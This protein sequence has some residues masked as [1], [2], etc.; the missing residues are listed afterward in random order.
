[1]KIYLHTKH[2]LTADECPTRT[3]RGLNALTYDAVDRYEVK[4][5]L[6]RG[7][8]AY[9]QLVNEVATGQQYAAKVVSAAMAGIQELMT[10]SDQTFEGYPEFH[11]ECA[12]LS[13]IMSP[14][15]VALKE[16]TVDRIEKEVW[17]VLEY[18]AA[19]CIS[20]ILGRNGQFPRARCTR[21][22][23]RHLSWSRRS[24]FCR[25]PYTATLNPSNVLLAS[26]GL[27]KIGDFGTSVSIFEA[28]ELPTSARGTE[29]Y[30]A[31]ELLHG[32]PFSPESDVFA[33]GLT[34]L[35]LLG[36][37]PQGAPFAPLL[38]AVEKL[39]PS[40][41]AA[42]LLDFFA[43]I[44]AVDPRSRISAAT[45][46]A[47]PALATAASPEEMRAFASEIAKKERLDREE[48]DALVARRRARVVAHEARRCNAD[49]SS[50]SDSDTDDDSYYHDD[51][52]ETGNAG[53]S[54]FQS[55]GC[56][57][58][59]ASVVPKVQK[60]CRLLSSTSEPES[61][62]TLPDQHAWQRSSADNISQL[63]AT[64]SIVFPRHPRRPGACYMG[65][66]SA[67]SAGM[68]VHGDRH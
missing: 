4:A 44:V 53:S 65:T 33:A 17:F 12:V 28:A 24:P 68:A 62:G 59:S 11:R 7:A 61:S 8:T 42:R 21:D 52:L 5:R 26:S 63:P 64:D 58:G 57:G 38:S 13:R 56:M 54:S 41:H 66:S 49:Y 37:K 2:A 29:G 39:S 27:A 15:L 30:F 10:S 16:M 47:H 40:Q 43:L 48:R 25:F 18:C 31:P 9:V 22:Y 36:L 60:D 35:E 3:Q 6:G 20:T 51:A 55:S 32:H 46:A 67:T 34:A 50:G 1:M 45:A 14:N 23:S 19:G